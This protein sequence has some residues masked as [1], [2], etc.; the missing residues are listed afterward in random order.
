VTN[1]DFVTVGRAYG[2]AEAALVMALLGAA[3]IK[4]YPDTWYFASADWTKT[5]AF[6]GI[7]LRVPT[8]QAADANTLL[9]EYPIAPR[10]RHWSRRLLAAA[11]FI[12]IFFLMSFPPPPSG[13]FPAA[14]RPASGRLAEGSARLS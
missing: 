12:A 6:G 3:G 14:L 4:V 10:P 11:V 8:D 2:Q 1:T 13:F 7:A 5:H 9:A